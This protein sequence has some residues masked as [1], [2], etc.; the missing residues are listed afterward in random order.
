MEMIG[1]DNDKYIELQSRY[2]L[3]QVE[4][5]DKLYLEFGGKLIDDYHAMRV[6]PGYDPRAKVKLL[7]E[8]REDTEIIISIYAGDIEHNKIRGDYGITYEE[9]VFRLIDEFRA[10]DLDVNSVVITRYNDEPAVKVFMHKLEQRNIKVYAQK[11]TEGYPFDVDTIVSEKGYGQNQYI[12]TEKS[13]VVLTAPGPNSGKLGVCLSQLYHETN[14]GVRA[15]YAKFETFPVWNLPLK[16]PVNI[17]YEAAT[18]EILDVNMIDPYHLEA[19]NKSAVNYNRD[20]EA[21]PLVRRIMAKIYGEEA[22]Y[23]SP[24]DMG[25]NQVGYSIIDDEVVREAANQEIIRRYFRLSCDYKKGIIEAS[26]AQ[27][28]KLLMDEMQLSEEDRVV[29]QPARDY[30]EELYNREPELYTGSVVPRSTAMQLPNGEIVT[31]KGS[32]AMS[33]ISACLLNA[34]KQMSGIADAIH[35]LSPVILEPVHYLKDDILHQKRH[36]LNALEILLTLS[37]SAATNPLAAEAMRKLEDLRGCQA[38][39]TVIPN[40]ADEEVCQQLGIDITADPVFS[41]DSIYYSG[42]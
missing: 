10:Y 24:T 17:A 15:G 32:S 16:H 3:E 11:Y 13:I 9:D 6:L 31:G 23:K 4:S 5:Y 12:E 18:A 2:I 37:I 25:V 34:I 27:R 26:V 41:G 21:F 19:Y 30:A 35:L 42:I 1:F 29:V 20:V 7:H 28:G 8:L 33:S 36:D 22:P 14:K 38:H 39:T 40:K